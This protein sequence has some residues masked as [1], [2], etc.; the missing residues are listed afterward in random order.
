[1]I[2]GGR[3]ADV[4]FEPAM[5]R[6]GAFAQFVA[7]LVGRGPGSG[8]GV[9]FILTGVLGAMVGVVGYLFPAVRNAEDLLPDHDAPSPG[10][11]HGS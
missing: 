7:P 5:A 4:L 8:M 11:A 10:E 3:L 2:A 6:G 9:L 1:M